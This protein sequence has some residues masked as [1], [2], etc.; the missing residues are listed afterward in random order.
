MGQWLR[1]GLALV[2]ETALLGLVGIWLGSWI[3]PVQQ[4]V[5]PGTAVIHWMRPVVRVPMRA[6]IQS[7][8]MQHRLRRVLP[9]RTSLLTV[10]TVP[11]V[12]SRAL[13][14]RKK[15]LRQTDWSHIPEVLAGANGLAH[16]VPTDIPI[17]GAGG[18]LATGLRVVQTHLACSRVF[19][20]SWNPSRVG[21]LWVAGR[22]DTSGRVTSVRTLRQFRMRKAP[23]ASFLKN[24]RNWRFVPL[25][26]DGHST[27]FHIVLAG[28]SGVPP[29]AQEVHLRHPLFPGG[30][31]LCFRFSG[32]AGTSMVFAVRIRNRDRVMPH[33]VL[34]PLK[35]HHPLAVLLAWGPDPQVGIA[36]AVAFYLRQLQ[37]RHH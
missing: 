37:N 34:Y 6:R 33:W 21:Y 27:W 16:G 3:S 29:Q 36:Q 1:V 28:L 35:G 19:H 5:P 18:L 20:W 26:I 7:H 17:P 14:L 23:V 32:M 25:R 13:R 15:A 8:A 30:I 2:V 31:S 11:S 24:I 12:L 9:P 10:L 22:V 4:Q